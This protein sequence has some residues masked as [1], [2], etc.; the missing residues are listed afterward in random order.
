MRCHQIV[1]SASTISKIA[2]LQWSFSQKSK[3]IVPVLV[4]KLNGQ[5]NSNKKPTRPNSFRKP[6][7]FYPKW[8]QITKWITYFVW[9][10]FLACN[11]SMQ[12]LCI[13]THSLYT[14]NTVYVL[15]LKQQK[16]IVPLSSDVEHSFSMECLYLVPERLFFCMYVYVCMCR[17]SVLNWHCFCER[18]YCHYKFLQW[19]HCNK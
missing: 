16:L 15:Y 10:R 14:P 19:A 8:K 6:E 11:N 18:M 4:A 13:E 9:I 7:F 12:W 17:T 1:S 2:W 5:K 3:G